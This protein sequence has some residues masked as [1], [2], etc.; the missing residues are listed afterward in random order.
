MR[1]GLVLL[2]NKPSQGQSW[3]PEL[4][5]VLRLELGQEQGLMSE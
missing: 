4:E 3:V 2:E 1:V 5:L